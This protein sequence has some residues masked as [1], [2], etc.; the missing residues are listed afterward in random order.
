M[1]FRTYNLCLLGFGNV[2]RTLV[3]L[4]E[5]RAPELREKY[6]ISFQITGIAS[7]S[8]GWI[9]DTAGLDPNARSNADPKVTNVAEWLAALANATGTCA[10]ARIAASRIPPRQICFTFALSNIFHLRCLDSPF[11]YMSVERIR[12]RQRLPKSLKTRLRPQ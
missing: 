6:G 2:N 4:L 10:P 9:A 11:T 3:R 8:L 12:N 5:D 1:K 7:R